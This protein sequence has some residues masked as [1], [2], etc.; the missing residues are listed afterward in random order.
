MLIVVSSSVNT[1]AE[2]VVNIIPCI[3]GFSAYDPLSEYVSLN[4]LV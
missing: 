1:G 4:T 3:G 2:N